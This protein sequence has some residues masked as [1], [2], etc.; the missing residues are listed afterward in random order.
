RVTRIDY[1]RWLEHVLPIGDCTHPV[2]LY[3]ALHHLDV[4]T[5]ELTPAGSTADLPDGVIYTVCG[6]RRATV[7]PACAEV[8]RAD[9]YQLIHA[10]IAGGK[11]V[12]A[13]VR[14]H[15]F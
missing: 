3:G 14:E 10:G 8:Y 12:P 13:T 2:R 7:C 11:G 5:G 4:A 9:T 15:P 1:Q 6:N